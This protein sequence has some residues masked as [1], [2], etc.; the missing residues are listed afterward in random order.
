MIKS[1]V[2]CTILRIG[3]EFYEITLAKMRVFCYHIYERGDPMYIGE[4][5][6][7]L[8]KQNKMTQRELAERLN[9]SDKVISK[10]ETG[11]SL[12]DVETMMRL[13]KV[14]GVS[15]SELYESVEKDDTRKI[16]AYSEERVWQYK[17]YSI[18]ASFLVALAPIMFFMVEF[19]WTNNSDIG[20][21]FIFFLT[22]VSIALLA[23]GLLFQITQYVRLYS[24]SKTKFYQ[25]EYKRT[26][27][28][29]GIIFLASFLPLILLILTIVAFQLS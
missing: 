26:L 25:S 23:T 21:V 11:K 7:E 14:L 13:S 27:R 28:K 12:P 19:A 8:R 2:I 20:D 4:K 1:T 3:E 18:V 16:E 17:K 6:A 15:I 22:M 9:V 24:F 5:I 10:W 29:Y